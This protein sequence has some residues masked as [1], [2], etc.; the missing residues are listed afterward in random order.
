[1]N[2]WGLKTV[3]D[4]LYIMKEYNYKKYDLDLYL[5]LVEEM[6]TCEEGNDIECDKLVKRT[7]ELI[8]EVK[9]GGLI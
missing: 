4:C 9:G 8:N 2:D 5:D 7:I 6:A 3:E 1:M